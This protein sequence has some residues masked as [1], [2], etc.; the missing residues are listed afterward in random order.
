MTST[1]T[2]LDEAHNVTILLSVCIFEANRDIHIA[3][4]VDSKTVDITTAF[5]ATPFK[6]MYLTQTSLLSI[7]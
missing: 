6:H 5:R 3:Y 2:L 1:A 4:V 7:S